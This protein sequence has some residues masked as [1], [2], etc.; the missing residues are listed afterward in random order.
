ME[1]TI[2]SAA[3]AVEY[4]EFKRSR[5]EAEIAMTLKKIIVNGARRDTDRFALKSACE[6]AKKLS[7]YGV[8]VSPVGVAAAKRHLEGSTTYVVCLVGGTG[9]T[10][11]A[12]KKTET[13]K[14]IAAGAREIRLV[15]CYSMLRS[16]NLQYLKREVKKIRRAVR[17]GTLSVSLE[18]HSLGEEEIALGVRAA[19]EGKADAVCVRGEVG[20]V[21]R[22]LRAA[23]GKI[24]VDASDIEN[25][26]QLRA[27]QKAGAALAETRVP[28]QLAE[29]LYAEARE[30]A[31]LIE[32]VRSPL[33]PPEET[34][35]PVP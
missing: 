19:V 21:L 2:L 15:L 18:D 26:E 32:T 27:L 10:L 11:M 3:E 29:E 9:E 1:G 35:P 25:A 5:R 12:V 22:A 14:V 7:A 30:E 28:E 17:K 6:S 24:R 34:K 13:K 16:G 31:G 4:G 23:A 33:V 8:L 20:L